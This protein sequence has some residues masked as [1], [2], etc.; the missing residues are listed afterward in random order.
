[1]RQ[2]ADLGLLHDDG[3]VEVEAESQ[4]GTRRRESVCV[5]ICSFGR[6]ES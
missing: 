5:Q 2:P 1:M 4:E 6:L 3:S